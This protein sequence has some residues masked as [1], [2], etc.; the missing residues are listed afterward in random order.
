MVITKNVT[1]GTQVGSIMVSDD[2]TVNVQFPG[3]RGEV[4]LAELEGVL[5][6]AH[7]LDKRINPVPVCKRSKRR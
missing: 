6:V 4:H 1:I 3:I 5:R 2:K 7:D